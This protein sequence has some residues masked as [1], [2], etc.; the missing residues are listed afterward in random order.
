MQFTRSRHIGTKTG[1]ILLVAALVATLLF[2]TA[3]SEPAAAQTPQPNP[4]VDRAALVALYN[5]ANGE[6]WRDN[7]NWLNDDVPLSEWYGVDTDASG[8]VTVLIFHGNNLT[9]TIPSELGNLSSLTS[10]HLDGNSMTGT[11]P[12]ELGNLSNLSELDLAD[13]NL[14]GTIPSELGNLSSLTWLDL[15]GNALTGTIPSELG[16][17]SSL[18]RLYLWDNE[19]TGTIPE[20]LGSLS[21]LSRLGLSDNELTGTIPH[22][23][24]NL[25]ELSLFT[26]AGNAGLCVPDD[27]AIQAWLNGVDSR[28]RADTG[29]SCSDS[30]RTADE[31]LARYDVDDSG[32]IDL[33]E[34]STAIDDYFRADDDP[35]KITLEQV[36]IVIDLYFS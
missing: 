18:T 11:I 5:A 19:L 31:L 27:E 24:T 28:F 13:N 10:L 29:P 8:R 15:G 21:N 22:S 12:K 9:G 3:T 35:D 16:N 36:S 14:T 23:L 34:V 26:F 7:T 6:N 1:L 20:E 33:S 17:L 25:T 32:R 30:G 2:F 4:S